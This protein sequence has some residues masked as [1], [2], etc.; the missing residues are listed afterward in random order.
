MEQIFLGVLVIGY[1]FVLPLVLII[2]VIRLNR[3]ID[4][5]KR[6]IEKKPLISSVEKE[7][8]KET[9]VEKKSLPERERVR[10]NWEL[11]IG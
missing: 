8:F 2:N 10:V 5:I 3:R 9:P 7:K 6:Y 4:D 11:E 1:V